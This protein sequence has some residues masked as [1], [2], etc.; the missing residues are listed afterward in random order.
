MEYETTR[1]IKW[2]I[3]LDDDEKIDEVEYDINASP[4]QIKRELIAF[5]GFDRD[6][7]ARMSR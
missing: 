1:R 6:I 3:W 7:D 4:S 2:E 5:D